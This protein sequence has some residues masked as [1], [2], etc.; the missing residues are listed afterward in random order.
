MKWSFVKASAT[1]LSHSR[2]SEPCEDAAHV[3]ILGENN[4]WFLGVVCDGAGSAR[5]GK[6]GANYTARKIRQC[7]KQYFSSNSCMPST[8]DFLEWIDEVRDGI[9]LAASKKGHRLRDYATTMVLV[10][11][12]QNLI[13]ICHIGDGGVVVCKNE[14]NEWVTV[15]SPAAGLYASETFFITDSDKVQARFSVFEG[16]YE[17][18]CLFSD[19]VEKVALDSS[20]HTPARKFFEPIA[21]PVKAIDG[22]GAQASLSGKLAE[23]LGGARI[24]EYSD[25]DKSLIIVVPK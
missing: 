3:A 16:N 10:V 4:N 2:R 25:D 1:G 8:N 20:D 7:A 21:R 6:L 5:F 14:P 22:K 19:G 17:T 15:S 23:F 24:N 18:I 11:A 12:E 9:S 13:H